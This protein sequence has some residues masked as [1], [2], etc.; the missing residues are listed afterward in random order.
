MTLTLL[1][2]PIHAIAFDFDGVFTDNRVLVDQNGVEAVWCHR[3]DGLGIANLRHAGMPMTVI[4]LETNPVVSARCAKLQLPHHG[5][6]TDK[7]QVFLNWLNE[8]GIAPEHALFMGNDVND[9][10]CLKAAG[11]GVCVADSHPDVLAIADLIL[12]KPGG[13]GAIRELADL[14]LRGHD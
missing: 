5:G 13:H 7:P 12:S 6:I 14:L 4:S 1:N 11:V 10:G 9:I 3:G 2:H 8:L